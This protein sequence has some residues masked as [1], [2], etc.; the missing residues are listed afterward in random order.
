MVDLNMQSL[1]KLETWYCSWY[2]DLVIF[3]HIIDRSV[4]EIR[5]VADF[6]FK[7]TPFIWGV[8]GDFHPD[9]PCEEVT[10][11]RTYT[12]SSKKNH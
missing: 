11:E 4:W 3:R 1:G 12:L 5:R 6:D 9:R 10:I 8:L 7:Y 2:K